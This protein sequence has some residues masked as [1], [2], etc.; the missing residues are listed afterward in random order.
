MKADPAEAAYWY[1]LVAA[2][3]EAKAFTNLGT[4]IARGWGAT[5]PDPVAAGLLWWVAAAR[6]EAIAM[7]DEGVLYERGIG[8]TDDLV[9]ARAWYERAAARNHSGARDALK[10]FGA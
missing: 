1:A 6:G 5:K 3:G 8:V 4:L 9:R 2:D 7:F 10:R